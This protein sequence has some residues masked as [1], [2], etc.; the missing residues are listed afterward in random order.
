MPISLW[1]WILYILFI[2]SKR[3]TMCFIFCRL[4]VSVIRLRSRWGTVM[5]YLYSNE[6]S[7]V[8]SCFFFKIDT[9]CVGLLFGDLHTTVPV[10]KNTKYKHK[11][12]KLSSVLCF[13]LKQETWR[14]LCLTESD[15]ET[16]VSNEFKS[17][18][19]VPLTTDMFICK[20][21]IVITQMR[22]E[23]Y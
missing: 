15:S 22:V 10:V 4:F 8:F 20:K 11:P 3:E 12:D 21:Q 5:N 7:L 23:F 19:I 9:S 17:F 16:G 14:I 1:S 13:W 2:L 6:S 18:H